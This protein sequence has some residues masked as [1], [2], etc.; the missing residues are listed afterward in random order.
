MAKNQEPESQTKGQQP[1]IGIS[2]CPGIMTWNQ[3]PTRRNCNCRAQCRGGSENIPCDVWEDATGFHLRSAPEP[4]LMCS[5]WW[6]Q[7]AETRIYYYRRSSYHRLANFTWKTWQIN[8]PSTFQN[9]LDVEKDGNSFLSITLCLGR[10]IE[11]LQICRSQPSRFQRNYIH[12]TFLYF[13]LRC[14]FQIC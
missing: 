8:Q 14:N 3:K 2:V 12:L 11:G 7:A 1:E 13:I 10:S 4:R 6:V 5:G 9:S